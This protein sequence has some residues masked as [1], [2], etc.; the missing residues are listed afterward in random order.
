MRDILTIAKKELKSI[1]SNKSIVAQMLL[2]PFGLIFGFIVLSSFMMTPMEMEEGN[3]LEYSYYVNAPSYFVTPFNELGLEAVSDDEIDEIKTKIENGDSNLLIVF[4]ENFELR[5]D[6]NNLC[7][8][9]MWYNSN[10]MDSTLA[11]SMAAGVLDSVRPVNF[12]VNI[13]DPESYD[14]GKELDFLQ[15]S[16]LMTFPSYALMAIFMTSLAIASESV[17][18]EKERGFMNLLLI[19]PIKRSGIAIGKLL[20]IFAVNSISGA[21]AMI[22]MFASTLF[23]SYVLNVNSMS[24]GVIEYVLLFTSAVTTSFAMSS[25]VL[26]ISSKS[27]TIK[28]AQNSS[29]VVMMVLMLMGIF[30]NTE[31]G[32]DIIKNIGEMNQLIPLWSGVFSMNNVLDGSIVMPEVLLAAGVNVVF[33]IIVA[34]A[35]SRLFEDEKIMQG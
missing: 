11:Q 22:G 28:Q 21:S 16:L 24:Y 13:N 7:N 12:T 31:P 6:A 29:T 33:A 30:S 15:Q 14:L 3:K 18:G 5:D 32:R 1:F 4:P 8:I 25:L 9:E 23:S 2:L 35:A 17:V 10:D 26:F 34:I 27:T 20:S 19:A